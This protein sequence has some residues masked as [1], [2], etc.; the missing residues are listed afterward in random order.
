MIL[1]W[2]ACSSSFDDEAVEL[3]ENGLPD[4]RAGLDQ[5]GCDT[6]AGE[7][8]AGAVAW[9]WGEYVED[10]SGYIGEERIL[11]FANDSW[12][13]LGGSDCVI[14]W[15]VRA[16]TTAPFSC[17]GCDFGLSVSATLSTD[18]TTC[19]GGLTAGD[20]EWTE[21]YDLS[22]NDNETADWYF[23]GSGNRFGTGYHNDV[24]V[25]YLSDMTCVWFG[26]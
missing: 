3:S 7:P 9:Y 2:L 20:E 5:E 15:N 4:L 6:L 16:N 21:D 22:L 25:N 19:P 18:Q 26:G 11:Y 24:A 8:L 14:S 17:T 12:E 10:E 1:L 13:A 23:A